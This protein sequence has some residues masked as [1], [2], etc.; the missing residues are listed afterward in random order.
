MVC[1]STGVL[2][3]GRTCTTSYAHNKISKETAGSI[4]IVERQTACS[5]VSVLRREIFGTEQV[6]NTQ[7]LG[8]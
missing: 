4:Y 8:T 6:Y 5:M 2:V 7:L 3:V 1:V